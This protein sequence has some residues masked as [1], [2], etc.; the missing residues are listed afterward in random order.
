ML[1][2]L[3]KLVGWSHPPSLSNDSTCWQQPRHTHT[4]YGY[5]N[6]HCVVAGYRHASR[7]K[8]KQR[9][10]EKEREGG[11]WHATNSRLSL[12]AFSCMCSI[13]WKLWHGLRSQAVENHCTSAMRTR[14]LLLLPRLL[15]QLCCAAVALCKRLRCRHFGFEFVLCCCCCVF[16]FFFF[17]LAAVSVGVGRCQK[18]MKLE[19]IAPS[20]TTPPAAAATAAA[21]TLTV[22]MPATAS[23]AEML[24]L[25]G[26]EKLLLRLC[27]STVSAAVSAA[28][29][30][31]VGLC[32]S[33][34]C[35]YCYFFC[36]FLLLH[37]MKFLNFFSVFF[38]ELLLRLRRL[39]MHN[40]FNSFR[41]TINVGQQKKSFGSIHAL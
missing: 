37:I 29:A 39:F 24:N 28:C 21:T 18:G 11:S 4:H 32:C 5:P 17:W 19:F 13:C 40:N 7:M 2:H 3:R 41:A 26:R 23:A 22:A 16:S 10:S 31:D 20:T 27:C 1:Y 14:W 12:T 25:N 9:V 6:A 8:E 33:L 36:C 38:G 30:A 15:L 35:C 34:R